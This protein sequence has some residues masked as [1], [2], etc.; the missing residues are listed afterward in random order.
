MRFQG[1]R[2][3]IS[4]DCSCLELMRRAYPHVLSSPRQ[5]AHSRRRAK[6]MYITSSLR[7]RKWYSRTPPSHTRLYSPSEKKPGA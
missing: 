5:T 3:P 1:T 2:R 7:I 6:L 4:R